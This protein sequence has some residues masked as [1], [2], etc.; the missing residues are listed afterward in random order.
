MFTLANKNTLI[1]EDF[2]VFA[3][4]VKTMLY[5]LGNQ[6]VEIVSNAEDAIQAC[7]VKKFDILLS[8]YNLGESKDG[9]QL[10]EE[11]MVFGLLSPKCIFIML[12]AENTSTMVMG[13]IEH[14]PDNY[15]AKPF[16]AA[17]LKSRIT[18]AVDKKETLSSITQNMDKKNWLEAINQSRL[19]A[20]ENPK[21]RMSC[22]RSEFKCLKKL[23]KLDDALNLSLKII[24]ERE[25]PWALQAVGEIYFLQ[26]KYDKAVGVFKNMTKKYPMNL[27]AYDCL[28]QTQIALGQSIDAQ[29]T[30]NTAITKAPK[31]VKRQKTLGSIAEENKDFNTMSNA[32][33]QA[34]YQGKHSALSSPDEY[35]KLTYGLKNLI[36]HN[37]RDLSKDKLVVEAE[38][39]FKQLESKFKNDTGTIIRSNV[40]HAAFSKAIK[41]KEDIDKYSNHA[42]KIFDDFE[43]V[44]SPQ[45]SLE[46]SKSLNEIGETDFA[47]AIIKEAIQQ[48]LDDKDF[49][50]Q[51]SNFT[52]DKNLIQNCKKAAQHNEKAIFYFSKNDFE[53]ATEY[54]KKA[55]TISPKNINIALNYTQALLK[56]SK[57]SKNKID[58][59]HSASDKLSELNRMETSDSRYARYSELNRLT[60]IMLS[61]STLR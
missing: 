32:F 53:S 17:L 10:L 5:S 58:I 3:R 59:L 44:L 49:I 57:K 23:N 9:Q 12:T 47:E 55:S 37:G 19:T 27:E 56:L 24:A 15:I 6:S 26:K 33:R 43:G 45:V 61:N 25:V 7:R 4:S 41:N 35:V 39:T 46:I 22:L 40:A 20:S 13:A 60:Q 54:F 16:T 34:I 50:K 21:Y 36:S 8:D 38:Q 2:T 52:Q 48:N 42:K 51:I 11:L 14:Q 28:A 30:I 31:I 29:E 18:K 1:I